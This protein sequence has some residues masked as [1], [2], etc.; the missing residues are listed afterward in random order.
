MKRM[1]GLGLAL[2]LLAGCVP[3]V[4]DMWLVQPVS[5]QVF[6]AEDGAPVVG[7]EVRNLDQPELT[8]ATGTVGEFAIEGQSERQFYMA[9]P[10]SYLNREIWVVRHPDYADAV[11]VT[12][13]LA[14]PR[15]RQPSLA[16]VP[17][18]AGLEQGPDECPFGH[19]RLRLAEDL[20]AQESLD[21]LTLRNLTELDGV[22]CRD[23]ALNDQWQDALEALFRERAEGGNR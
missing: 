10:A 9:M 6:D 21:D 23:P 4:T 13:T 2:M 11:F 22:L 1:F 16:E 14:P 5:G 19:Y 20:R 18:F 8:T 15:S 7:A 17:M 3:M 12:R